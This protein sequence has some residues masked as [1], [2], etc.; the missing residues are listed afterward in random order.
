MTEANQR[1]IFFTVAA[2]ILISTGIGV[3]AI[4]LIHAGPY[5]MPHGG[6]VYGA[7]GA[8]L[9]AAILIYRSPRWLC[10]TAIALSP[11]ALFPALYSIM[12]E[13]EEVIS[14][15][16]TDSKNNPVDLRLWIVDR[17]DGAWLGMSRA[18]AVEHR[19]DG[20]RVTMLRQ[21]QTICVI[22]VLHDK[23]R[24]TVRAIH[25]MKVE[26]YAVARAAG[27]IGLYPLEA[28]DS[29]VV[30]RLDPCLDK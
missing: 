22:P 21:G 28:T 15:Y 14:L 7:F 3:F 29:T 19:L 5:V 8:I 24:A 2:V 30:I 26:K 4:R 16:A 1:S 17:E 9:L 27:L 12:G 13:S 6:A 18:K 23:D 25:R 10:W 20:N 11:V